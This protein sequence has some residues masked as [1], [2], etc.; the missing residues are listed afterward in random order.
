MEMR[1]GAAV[2]VGCKESFRLEVASR[3]GVVAA[4]DDSTLPVK[5]QNGIAL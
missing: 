4:A 5:K 2:M 1:F 3:D